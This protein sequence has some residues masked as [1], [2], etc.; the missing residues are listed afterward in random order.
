[1]GIVFS[2]TFV[3][4]VGGNPT[5]DAYGFRYWNNPVGLCPP[6]KPTHVFFYSDMLSSNRAHLPSI[7]QQEQWAASKA[8]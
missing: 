7:S 8:S 1:M 5:H 2:F 4:M 3:T 6:S